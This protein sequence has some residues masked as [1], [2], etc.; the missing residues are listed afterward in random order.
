MEETG[1]IETDSWFVNAGVSASNCSGIS[2][3]QDSLPS[4]LLTEGAAFMY[5]YVC[6][7]P[8]TNVSRHGPQC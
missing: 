2:A 3:I 1:L 6:A 7:N 5:N 4:L 8:L